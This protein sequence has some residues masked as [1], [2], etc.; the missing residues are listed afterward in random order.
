MK[1]SNFSYCF[2]LDS[3]KSR[4]CSEGLCASAV[5]LVKGVTQRSSTEG[6]GNKAEEKQLKQAYVFNYSLIKFK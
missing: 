1:L 5:A 6:A 2:S 3:L 4:A